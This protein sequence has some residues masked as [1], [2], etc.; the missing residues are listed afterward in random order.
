MKVVNK[1]LVVVCAFIVLALGA[2]LVRDFFRMRASHAPVTIVLDPAQLMPRAATLQ[3]IPVTVEPVKSEAYVP[4]LH[5]HWQHHGIVSGI[6]W[7]QTKPG[8]IVGL[9]G[10]LLGFKTFTGQ[11][12]F[13]DFEADMSPVDLR[14]VYM[15]RVSSDLTKKCGYAMQN[16]KPAPTQC[17]VE[18]KI[19]D[20][21]R[22]K[23]FFKGKVNNYNRD[24]G[25]IEKFL[26]KRETH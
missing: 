12:W 25:D 4:D 11:V 15:V 7:E 6:Y 23:N 26:R 1:S 13:V 10:G 18:E 16:F 22:S 21:K 3:A 9:E 5:G 14:Q 8:T 19:L 17:I 2:I 20:W 24:F